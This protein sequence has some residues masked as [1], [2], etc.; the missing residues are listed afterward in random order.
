M[1]TPEIDIA[2]CGLAS[3]EKHSCLPRTNITFRFPDFGVQ[4]GEG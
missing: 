2:F 1:I 4:T 3:E